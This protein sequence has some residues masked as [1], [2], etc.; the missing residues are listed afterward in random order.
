MDATLIRASALELYREIGNAATLSE[1]QATALCEQAAALIDQ[2]A[3]TAC[4]PDKVRVLACVAVAR[5]L[6]TA[7]QA[8]GGVYSPFGDGGA[9]R[10]ARD[11]MKAAYPLLAPYVGGGFA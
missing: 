3:R 6:H 1:Q 11:P 9:V 8:P 10:L 7:T 5:D 2:H 4:I